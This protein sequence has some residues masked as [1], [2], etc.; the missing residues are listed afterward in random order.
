MPTAFQTNSAPPPLPAALGAWAPFSGATEEE[1]TQKIKSFL[2]DTDRFLRE[3]RVPSVANVSF[4]L[5]GIP[6]HARH[7]PQDDKSHL[8]IW[9]L[10]GYLPYSVVSHAKREALISIVE[11]A[12]TLPHIKF[13]I[14]PHM[15]IVVTAEYRISRPPSPDYLFAPLCHM[16]Q[17]AKP[18]IG[19]IAEFL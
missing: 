11:G 19:L 1:R 3:I 18:F 8:L 2:H 9:G 12:Q 14:A 15:R 17:E 16:M 5:N 10:L 13:G 6:F 4:E 7:E